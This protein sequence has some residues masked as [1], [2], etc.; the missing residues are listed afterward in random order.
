MIIDEA[1]KSLSTILE[2]EYSNLKDTP[3]RGGKYDPADTSQ[4]QDT[5]SLLSRV[6]NYFK[7]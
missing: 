2:V 7:E 1:N 6:E 5:Q 3:V 4:N